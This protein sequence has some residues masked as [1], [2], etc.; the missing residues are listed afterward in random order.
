VPLPITAIGAFQLSGGTGTAAILASPTG[1]SVG[2]VGDAVLVTTHIASATVHITAVASAAPAGAATFTHLGGTVSGAH[3]VDLWLGVITSAP[4]N[5]LN[6]TGS[7]AI[8]STVNTYTVQTISAGGQGTTW[9]ADGSMGT[10]TNAVASTT[11]TYPSLTPA[12]AQELY[13]GYGIS[14]SALTTGATA[15]YTVHTDT[16]VNAVLWDTNVSGAQS[17]TS[18]QT[19]SATSVGVG[20]LISATPA[21]GSS[22]Q[23]VTAFSSPTGGTALTTAATSP[24]LVGNLLVVWGEVHSATI[25]YTTLSG[26]GVTTWTHLIGPFVGTSGTYS[27]DMWMGV[28]TA[29]GAATVTAAASG[30][31]SGLQTALVVEE[32]TLHSS[33]AIWAVDTTGSQSNASSTTC[34]FP[35]LTPAQ[36]GELYVGQCYSPTGVTGSAQTGY[37]A[38][39]AWNLTTNNLLYNP[40]VTGVQAPALT[41]STGT[42]FSIGALI[43]GKVPGGNSRIR[44]VSYG[45]IQRASTY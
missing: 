20:C 32:F 44:I 41:K 31:L 35:S 6:F 39:T 11:I 29:T 30:S 42:S 4:L 28:V 26:G 24:V 16:P 18:T 2:N 9:A 13:F 38:P 43:S 19:S 3:S 17:P 8:T 21:P 27:M 34:G 23:T 40:Q 1:A 5:Q 36:G 15:G 33:T 12:G 25:H 10:S 37:T 45:A 7:A 22:I 14:G